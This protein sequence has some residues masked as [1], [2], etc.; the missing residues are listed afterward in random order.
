MEVINI[1]NLKSTGYIRTDRYLPIAI[2]PDGARDVMAI[3]NHEYCKIM[4]TENAPP[5]KD[6]SFNPHL[7][8]WIAIFPWVKKAQVNLENKK[9][10]KRMY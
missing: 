3:A 8:V 6:M 7:N 5:I 4:K 2:Y 9:W 10:T 1:Q